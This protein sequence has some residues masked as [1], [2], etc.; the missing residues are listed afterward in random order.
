VKLNLNGTAREVQAETIAELLIELETP[1]RG[2][3]VALNGRVIPRAEH[4]TT[5]LRPDDEIELV[6]AVQGG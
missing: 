5:P 3:A 1:P 2:V 6:I 4:A